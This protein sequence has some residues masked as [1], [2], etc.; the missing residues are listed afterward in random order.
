MDV[1][2]SGWDGGGEGNSCPAFPSGRKQKTAKF[3]FA[4]PLAAA[5]FSLTCSVSS[6]PN[7]AQTALEWVRWIF[8]LSPLLS[9]A[10]CWTFF[11]SF[12]F[13]PC[14]TLSQRWKDQQQQGFPGSRIRDRGGKT[15]CICSDIS[16][17]DGGKKA[18]WQR[19]RRLSCCDCFKISVQC[20]CL[21]IYENSK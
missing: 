3:M 14:A 6:L 1:K 5:V 16:V 10:I 18:K 13:C 15:G 12:S 9:K 11:R 2:G 7:L 21:R 17:G 8:P 20:V 4:L 19:H